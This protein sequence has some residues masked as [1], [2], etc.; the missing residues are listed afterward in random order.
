MKGGGGIGSGGIRTMSGAGRTIHFQRGSGA[1]FRQGGHPGVGARTIGTTI[2][3]PGSRT[4]SFGRTSRTGIATRQLGTTSLAGG[5]IRSGSWR[6][7]GTAGAFRSAPLFSGGRPLAANWF[8][9]RHW[10]RYGYFGWAG[11]LFWPYAYDDIFYDVFWVY[12]YDDPFWYYGYP[13][14]YGGLFLP[15]P[16]DEL[17]GWF[18][19]PT[20]RTRVARTREWPSR[21]RPDLTCSP[22]AD[23]RRRRP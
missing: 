1:T 2:R 6:Q 11:P 3:Q 22:D 4:A 17:D 15:Y 14:L 23:V 19:Q 12:G 9:R 7:F 5:A 21:P 18:A 10:R 16:P 13:D 8:A 20:P